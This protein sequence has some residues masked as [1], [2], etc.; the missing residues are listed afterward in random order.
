MSDAATTPNVPPMLDEALEL[1]ELVKPSWPDLRKQ[2]GPLVCEGEEEED[3]ATEPE[4]P[5]TEEGPDTPSGEVEGAGGF[6]DFDLSGV[7][8]DLHEQVQGYAQK[9]KSHFQ[10]DYTRKAQE[11][12]RMREEAAEPERVL[13]ALEDPQMA[14]SIL[15]QIA[16]RS[17]AFEF[18]APEEEDFDEL[19]AEGDPRVDQLQEQFQQFTTRQ[20]EQQIEDELLD[21]VADSI[22]AAEKAEGREFDENERRIINNFAWTNPGPDGVPDVDGGVSL[23]KAVLKQRQSELLAGRKPPRRLGPGSPA[24]KKVNLD[25]P[26]QQTDA[27]VEAAEE[28]IASRA[29]AA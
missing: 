4:E 22:E 3:G 21:Y 17:G 20:E 27:M 2:T 15:S 24:S 23:L 11:L 25:D 9:V 16:Q 12:A 5:G 7:P 10:G 13:A 6:P 28:A 8:E 19:Y 26:A 14:P 29:D 18:E 1:A